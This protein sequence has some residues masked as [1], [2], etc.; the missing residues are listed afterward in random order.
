M[1]MTVFLSPK[2]L[3]AYIHTFR[4]MHKVC[5]VPLVCRHLA[6]I[7]AR[8]PSYHLSYAF[9]CVLV[10]AHTCICW[11][12]VFFGH[13]SISMYLRSL[14]FYFSSFSLILYLSLHL[15]IVPFCHFSFTLRR[16]ISD[17]CMY[18]HVITFQHSNIHTCLC[19][20]IHIPTYIYI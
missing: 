14:I 7:A 18:T 4:Y 3:H 19:V 8:F 10:L 11:C 16:V 17:I 13:V 1:S 5:I 6:W 9:M 15:L 2:W 12:E 20:Y